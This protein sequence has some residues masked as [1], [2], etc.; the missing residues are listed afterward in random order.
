MCKEEV[1]SRD[2]FH[3]IGEHMTL[4]SSNGSGQEVPPRIGMLNWLDCRRQARI[5][6]QRGNNCAAISGLHDCDHREREEGRA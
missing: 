3:Q 6:E 2:Q 1:S 5:T 4:G